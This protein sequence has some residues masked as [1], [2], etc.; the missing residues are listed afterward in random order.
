MYEGDQ[1]VYP[2]ATKG[3]CY[4][5]S[6]SC[7][8]RRESR[9]QRL[10]LDNASF[11]GSAININTVGNIDE[12]LLCEGIIGEKDGRGLSGVGARFHALQAIHELL[13]AET[14]R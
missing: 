14:S 9:W 13:I 1:L 12:L 7:H 4:A 2:G 5:K 3:A 6:D 10:R 11:L 8:E